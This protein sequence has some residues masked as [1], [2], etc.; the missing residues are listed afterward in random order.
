MK[1]TKLVRT[2]KIYRKSEGSLKKA[3]RKIL[4]VTANLKNVMI[5]IALLIAFLGSFFKIYTWID[6]TYAKARAVEQ[7]KVENDY[8]WETTVL[9]GMYSRLWTL[10]NMVNLSPDPSKIAPEVKTEWNDLKAKIKMQEEKV[11][12]LQEKVVK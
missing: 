4:G 12:V 5:A 2:R 11:K 3:E 8:R 1:N 9:N 6:T 10:D 7:V